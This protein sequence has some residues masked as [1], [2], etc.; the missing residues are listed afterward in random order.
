M[1]DIL[2]ELSKAIKIRKKYSSNESYTASLINS[3]TEK[4]AKKFGEEAVELVIAALGEDLESFNSEVADTLY[5]LL[6]LIE[7]RDADLNDILSIL[8]QRQTMSGHAEKASRK[9]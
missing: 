3:G 7:S 2:S 1:N 6:V 5:H 8:A 9:N 4:C